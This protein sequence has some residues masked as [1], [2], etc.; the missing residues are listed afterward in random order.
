MYDWNDLRYFLAVART[1]STLAASRA[2]K[3]NQT[4]VARRIGVLERAIGTKL[5]D[6][7]R[8]GYVITEAGAELR[9]SAERAEVEAN[10]FAE[11]AGAIGRRLC[12]VIRVTTSEGLAN[13]LMVPALSAFRELHPEVRVDLIID[14]RRL[15]LMRGEADVAL[16]TG[17]PP[18]ENGLV[19]RRLDSLAWAAYCSRDYAE[20]RGCPSAVDALWKHPVVGADGAIAALPGWTWL[21]A[22]APDAEVVARTSSITNLISAVKAGLGITVLPCVLADGEPD[23]VRCIGPIAGVQSD[24]WLMTREDARDLRRVRA[25]LDFLAAHVA[26]MRPLLAGE[27]RTDVERPPHRLMKARTA[28]T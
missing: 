14:E 1:G 27:A 22:A 15:D 17:A 23:L 24:L 13:V 2:L 9:A 26:A 6:K 7:R 16:R 18:T 3:T 10:G 4:T 20:R 25:F 11:R 21:Q 12:G 19:G 8:T 5:F 28:A